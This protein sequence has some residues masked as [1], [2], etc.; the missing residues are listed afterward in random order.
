MIRVRGHVIA[1]P[2]T[3]DRILRLGR[4]HVL[5]SRAEPGS[6]YDASLLRRL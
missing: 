2:E 1:Q 5:R 4:A 3:M 6:I